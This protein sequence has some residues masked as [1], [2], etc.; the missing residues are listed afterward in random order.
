MNWARLK[1]GSQ[2]VGAMFIPADVQVVFNLIRTV[3][4]AEI[5]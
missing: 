2:H 5:D 4:K 3:Q 1:Q